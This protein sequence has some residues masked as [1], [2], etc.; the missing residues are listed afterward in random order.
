MSAYNNTSSTFTGN[1]GLG[2]GAGYGVH[3]PTTHQAAEVGKHPVAAATHPAHPVVGAEAKDAT[4]GSG[5]S[6]G[7]GVGA[8]RGVGSNTHRPS[9][10]VG[11]GATDM[12]KHPVSAAEHPSHPAASA[13][14]EDARKGGHL[15]E[16]GAR[17]DPAAPNPGHSSGH[18]SSAGHS[19]TA[20]SSNPHSHSGP[21]STATSTSEHKPSMGDKISGA[22]EAV[23]GKVTGN[24]AKV[25]E[26]QIRKTEG[27]EAALESGAHHAVEEGKKQ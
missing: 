5:A 25:A 21:G 2:A 9:G 23:V 12:A 13:H 10:G 19:S 4:Y 11:V 1:T 24:H 6:T 7:A 22:L 8:G 27:K 18:G 14:I 3:D 16:S 17:H 15:T 26:G 20:A